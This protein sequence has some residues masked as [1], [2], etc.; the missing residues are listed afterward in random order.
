MLAV[1]AAVGL[2]FEYHLLSDFV[3]L[4]NQMKL[5]GALLEFVK[6]PLDL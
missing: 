6:A 5:A 2:L 1:L 3:L 4:G